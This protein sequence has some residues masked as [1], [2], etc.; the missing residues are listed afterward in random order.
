MNKT[1]TQLYK[2]LVELLQL[3]TTPDDGGSYTITG[4]VEAWILQSLGILG[5][6]PLDRLVEAFITFS[7]SKTALSVYRTADLESLFA[8]F[9]E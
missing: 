3:G 8:L 7:T 4:N 9:C 6:V 2:G 1:K 5:P